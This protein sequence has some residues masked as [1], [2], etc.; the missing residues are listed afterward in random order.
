MPMDLDDGG[1]THRLLHIQIGCG[2]IEKPLENTAF[3]PVPMLFEHIIP[4][5]K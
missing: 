2:R 1:I 4:F 3:D 5:A